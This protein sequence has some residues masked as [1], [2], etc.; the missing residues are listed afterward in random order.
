MKK[1]AFFKKSKKF[2]A[3]ILALSSLILLCT[4]CKNAEHLELTP[5]E[6]HHFCETYEE[7]VIFWKGALHCVRPV[8][9][10]LED[11]V[12]ISVQHPHMP[13]CLFEIKSVEKGKNEG[14]F[15]PVIEIKKV[16]S[17]DT[18]LEGTEDQQGVVFMGEGDLSHI[19]GKK[20]LGWVQPGEAKGEII[21]EQWTF[22]VTEDNRLVSTYGCQVEEAQAEAGT[23]QMMPGEH[24]SDV[25]QESREYTGQTL[26][27]FV[28]KVKSLEEELQKEES[29]SAVQ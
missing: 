26:E 18:S 29:L 24:Y 10:S 27:Y 5:K 28:E 21:L 8:S 14:Y 6:T 23:I 2:L 13:L 22:L 7:D 12:R 4:S 25:K 3:I 9:P 1:K 19:V 20:Y 15:F 16:Y 11:T 17:G